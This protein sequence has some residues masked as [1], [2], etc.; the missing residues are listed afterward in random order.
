MSFFQVLHN[1]V[2]PDISPG[3]T[4]PLPSAFLLA[5]VLQP[6][7]H[8]NGPSLDCSISSTSFLCWVLQALTQNS[9][10]D[11]LYTLF[12]MQP[13]IL[14]AFWAARIHIQRNQ[15]Y[16][17]LLSP[18]YLCVLPCSVIVRTRI[19]FWH[20]TRA[21]HLAGELSSVP[22]QIGANLYWKNFLYPGI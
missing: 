16:N 8:L 21:V 13:K 19:S 10:W 7:D 22:F 9:R 14:L 17:L 11:L 20:R 4:S 5:E 15:A 12:L 1:E 6:F 2:S 18:L 3:E